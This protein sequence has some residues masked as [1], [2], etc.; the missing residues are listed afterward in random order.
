MNSKII[1]IGD[2]LGMEM[3]KRVNKTSLSMEDLEYNYKLGLPIEIFCLKK[4]K[5][6]A[7]GR[8]EAYTEHGVIV[9]QTIYSNK[10]YRFFGLTKNK[11]MFHL[12]C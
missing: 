9:N 10:D 4:M 3:M 11:I 8:I 7:F 5:T 1:Q 12:Q 2:E 6:V